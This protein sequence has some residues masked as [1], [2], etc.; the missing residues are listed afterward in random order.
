MTPMHRLGVGA[1]GAVTLALL[2]ACAPPAAGDPPATAAPPAAAS[3]SVTPTPA[4][5]PSAKPSPATAGFPETCEELLTVEQ[6]NTAT[7]FEWKRADDDVV[8]PLPGPLA[9]ETAAA[10]LAVLDCNWW[11][12]V[13]QDG[14]MPLSAFRLEPSAKDALIAGLRKSTPEYVESVVGGEPS[15]SAQVSDG[16]FRMQV[17]YAFVGD[18]WLALHAPVFADPADR[19]IVDAAENVGLLAG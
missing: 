10:A 6:L 4:D 1:V 14:N 13:A 15:F 2:T 5:T 3:P 19:I 18:V 12:V 7:E 9:R 16:M 8:P 17:R 11:P